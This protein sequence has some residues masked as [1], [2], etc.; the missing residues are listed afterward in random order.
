MGCTVNYSLISRH[1][2]SGVQPQYERS[3]SEVTA[4]SFLY[5]II[6]FLF[7]SITTLLRH[8]IFKLRHC[9][10]N[11]MWQD[12]VD[13]F[14]LVADEL[15]VVA[16]RLRAMVVAEVLLNHMS[17]NITIISPGAYS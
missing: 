5:D 8:Y 15:S 14:S 17:S 9:M 4:V 16:N 13:P 10:Y 6:P 12:Q 7:L 3:S 11:I 2:S 1:F